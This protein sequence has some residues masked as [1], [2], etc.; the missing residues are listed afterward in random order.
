MDQNT[1]NKSTDNSEAKTKAK[2]KTNTNTKTNTKTKQPIQKNYERRGRYVKKKQNPYYQQNPYYSHYQ[3]YYPNPNPKYPQMPYNFPN[4]YMQMPMGFEYQQ[5][6][7]KYPQYPYNPYEYYNYYY[8]P[9]NIHHHHHQRSH[10]RDFN[11]HSNSNSHSHS[12][13]HSQKPISPKNSRKN[14]IINKREKTSDVTSSTTPDFQGYNF[15]RNLLRGI[16]E[17]GYE[18]PSPIQ[19]QAIPLILKGYDVVA[20]AK[21]GTGKTATFLIP[22]IE[23]I[24]FSKNTV[25]VLI[26]APTKELAMQI[27]IETK[28]LGNFDDIQVMHLTGGSKI[29]EDLARLKKTVHVLVCTIGKLHN[30][31]SEGILDLSNVSVLIMDEADKLLTEIDSRSKIEDV[32]KLCPQKKQTLLFSATFPFEIQSFIEG[33]LHQV[34]YV[35]TMDGLTLLGVKQYYV[36]LNEDQKIICLNNLFSS[37][38][39]NQSVIFCNTINRV[40]KLR[41]TILDQGYSCLYIHS[42]MSNEERA[43]VFH[44]F[45]DGKVRHLIAS[46]VVTRGIDNQSVNVVI[47]F[48]FP[49]NSDTYLHRIGRSGRFGHRGLAIS[50]IT[51]PDEPSILKI[52]EELEHKIEP[53]PQQVDP[54]LYVM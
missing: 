10:N 17:C 38:Q 33:N 43:Q 16:H 7:P 52:E 6:N 12:N 2:T 54:S 24:D 3:P 37:L 46:D 25:Q 36:S 26:I 5:N 51:N 28:K 45:R 23:K 32:M 53:L 35:N 30:F 49:D 47:N 11:S 1:P 29:D 20:R 42:K 15:H 44:N 14:Q 27:S 50:F 13:S 34:K 8:P 48:D 9:P 19:E 21:N 40:E 39:I 41:Q 18:K 4:N 31:A 22:S